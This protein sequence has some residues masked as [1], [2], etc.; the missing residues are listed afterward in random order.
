MNDGQSNA[1]A[2]PRAFRVVTD[3]TG[4]RPAGLI[5]G[6][7]SLK[8]DGWRFIP[9][10]QASPSRRGWPTPEAAL[11]GRVEHFKLEAINHRTEESS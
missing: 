3:G 8:S 4:K 1:S 10:F 11:R 6:S 7:V 9:A 2:S 5:L